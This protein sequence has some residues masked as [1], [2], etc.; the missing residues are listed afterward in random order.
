MSIDVKIL[1]TVDSTLNMSEIGET[2]LSLTALTAAINELSSI[3]LQ[4]IKARAIVSKLV[5]AQHNG[6]KQNAATAFCSKFK[7]S[8]T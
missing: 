8:N 1:S 2:G 6:S 3:S 4:E 7:S 5:C